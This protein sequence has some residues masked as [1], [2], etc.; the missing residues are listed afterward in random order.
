MLVVLIGCTDPIIDV[1]PIPRAYTGEDARTRIP[2]NLPD[3]SSDFYVFDAG[4][5]GGSI[6]YASF[7]CA[8]LEDSWAAVAALGAP[9]E[10][11]FEKAIRS[12]YAVN[13][14]GPGFYWPEQDTD[15]WRFD[16]G[17]E[18]YSYESARGDRRMEFWA[19]DVDAKRVYYH[20]ES[21]GFP[22]DPP[23]DEFRKQLDDQGM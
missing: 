3:S 2:A 22:T 17:V 12:E 1:S 11:E 6:F 16:T 10:D 9:S 20:S 14:E 13:I 7:S 4:N 18:G 15:S 23:Q 8:S 21:G 19:I 5:F